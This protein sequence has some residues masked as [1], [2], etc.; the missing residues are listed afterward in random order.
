M[1]G[2]DTHHSTVE[3]VPAEADCRDLKAK[4]MQ[5]AVSYVWWD[6]QPLHSIVG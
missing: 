2:I 3:Q 5:F 4:F 1:A 6:A